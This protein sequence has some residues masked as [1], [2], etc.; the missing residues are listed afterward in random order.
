MNR[1]RI[2]KKC[3]ELLVTRYV[4]VRIPHFFGAKMRVCPANG[5]C[6]TEGM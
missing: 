3:N 2:T 6:N 4:K 5:E 1:Y